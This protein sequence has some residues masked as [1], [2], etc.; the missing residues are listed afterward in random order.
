MS[1]EPENEEPALDPSD[2]KYVE[3]FVDSGKEK[4]D[5]VN[6]DQLAAEDPESRDEIEALSEFDRI[7]TAYLNALAGGL[8]LSD[9][10]VERASQAKDAP[11]PTGGKDVSFRDRVNAAPRQIGDYEVLGEVGQ[12]GFATVF[13]ARDEKAGR[14]VAIKILNSRRDLSDEVVKRFLREARNLAKLRHE[15]IV[16]IYHV[17]DENSDLGLCMEY[18]AGQ[19]LEEY[20]SKQ[21][22]LAPEEVA[23]IGVDICGA[24][25]EVQK[26]GLIHRDIKADNIMREESGGRIV[27]MD[28]GI[29]RSADPQ[30]RVTATG[31]LIGTPLAMA[32]E[33]YEFLDVDART[34]VYS[35]GCL[36]YRMITGQ[37]PVDGYTMEEIRRKVLGADYPPISEIVPEISPALEAI[38]AKAMSK[39]PNRRYQTADEMGAAL[40]SWKQDPNAVVTEKSKLPMAVILLLVAILGVLI[41]ILV[42]SFLGD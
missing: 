15:N 4:D 38:I 18:I 2:S 27:L 17:I 31:V 10:Q 40:S 23:S 22:K 33:Q 12:G 3:L 14:D 9:S 7:R 13:R 8:A 5:D 20:L 24:L 39:D 25:S 30:T 16:Q 34:D 11:K 35:T 28:F 32:P 37:H 42:S 26:A 36:L 29:S 1:G 41:A 6:W 21:K 19:S